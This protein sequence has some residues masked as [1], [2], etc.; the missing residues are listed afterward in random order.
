MLSR[1]ICVR[2]KLIRVPGSLVPVGCHNDQEPELVWTKPVCTGVIA[3]VPERWPEDQ[4]HAHDEQQGTIDVHSQCPRSRAAQRAVTEI[5]L[6]RLEG[7]KLT[8]PVPEPT[9]VFRARREC[10]G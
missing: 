2:L 3:P 5:L 6:K 8:A 9:Q 4:H 1:S 7:V 10:P